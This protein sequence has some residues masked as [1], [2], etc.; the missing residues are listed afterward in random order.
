MKLF[1]EYKHYHLNMKRKR[2]VL[3]NRVPLN[4]PSDQSQ[5]VFTKK[6]DVQTVSTKKG[7]TDCDHEEKR[8]SKALL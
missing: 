5:T 7:C 2:G 4:D 1:T 8:M 3:L 6:K